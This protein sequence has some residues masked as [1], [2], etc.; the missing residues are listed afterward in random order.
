ML[1]D[2]PGMWESEEARDTVVRDAARTLAYV[3]RAHLPALLE[4]RGAGVETTFEV[5]DHRAI[6]AARLQDRVLVSVIVIDVGRSPAPEARHFLFAR[7]LITPWTGDPD[8]DAQVLARVR[9]LFR[10]H[11]TVRPEDIEGQAIPGDA[12]ILVQSADAY[13]ET[14]QAFVWRRMGHEQ[15]PSLVYRTRIGKDAA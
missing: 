4:P 7:H 6:A 8:A 1:S 14:K 9:E 13:D 12:K 15:K 3:L 5:P 11:E 10:H 2:H